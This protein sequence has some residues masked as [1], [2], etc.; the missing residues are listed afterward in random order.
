MSLRQDSSA[1]IFLYETAG[2][3]ARRSS[4]TW[5]HILRHSPPRLAR[6]ASTSLIAL[7]LS[8][9]SAIASTAFM[10]SISR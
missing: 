9:R 8:C 6:R 2:S 7:A 1:A 10:A 3:R 5:R 4:T